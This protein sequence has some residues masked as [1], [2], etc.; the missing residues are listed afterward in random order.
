MQ[1]L[2]RDSVTGLYY[3]GQNF[4]T[5][6][7]AFAYDFRQIDRAAEFAIQE[8]LSAMQIILNYQEPP[9]QI[10]LPVDPDWIRLRPI[11]WDLQAA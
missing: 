3:T 11:E 1:V 7:A 10:T 8:K 6:D 4:R 2:L 9:C 5:L